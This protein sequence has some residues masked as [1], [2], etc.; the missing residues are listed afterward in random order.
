MRS[1]LSPHAG[2]GERSPLIHLSKTE[3]T[4]S[5]SRGAF[6]PGSA[7]SSPLA[8][9]RGRRESRAPTAPAASCVKTKQHTSVVTIGTAETSRLSPR[10]FDGLLRALPGEAAFVATVAAGLTTQ[11]DARVAAPG[12]HDFAVRCGRS[13]PAGMNPPDATASFASHRTVRDDREPPLCRV[14]RAAYAT[15]L[16]LLKSGIFFRRGLDKPMAYSPFPNSYR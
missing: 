9:S 15:D 11:L 1:G 10:R 4:P 8:S 3:N 5:H 2:R 7:S 12:P 6:R 16:A 13:R 14:G